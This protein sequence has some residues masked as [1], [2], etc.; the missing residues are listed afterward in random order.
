MSSCPI[1]RV[2]AVHVLS[3]VVMLGA[4]TSSATVVVSNET[5]PP[6]AA[7]QLKFFLSKPALVAKGELV[8][9]LDPTVFGSITTA[10]AFSANGD[11]YGFA[12]ISGLNVDVVFGSQSGG[13]GQLVGMPIVTVTA[14]VL[15]TATVGQTASVTP[16]PTLFGWAD[17]QGNA[18]A[19]TASAGTVTVGGTLSI[20]GVTPGGGILPSGTSIEIDGTGFS[21]AATVHI[22]GASIASAQVSNAGKILVTLGGATELTGKPVLVTN[23]DGSE[24]VAFSFLPRVPVSSTGT[25]F[26]GVVPIMPLQTY[27]VATAFVGGNGLGGMAIRNPNPMAAQLLVDTTNAVGDFIGEQALT[28][29]AGGSILN[30]VDVSTDSFLVI[31]SAPVQVVQ[32]TQSPY[33]PSLFSAAP[34]SAATVPALQVT[35]GLQN[36]ALSWV[37]QTGGAGP[38]AQTIPLQ[39]P[40]GLPSTNVAV[41]IATSS[42][43]NWLSVTPAGVIACTPSSCSSFQVSANPA[44][45]LPGIYRGTVT[46]TPVATSLHAAVV[47]MVIPVAITVTASSIAGTAITSVYLAPSSLS[48]AVTIPSGLFSGSFSLSIV[49]DSGGNWLSAV[50]NAGSSPSSIMVTANAAGF[51]VGSY[52]GDIVISGSGNTLVVA[53]HFQVEGSIR[54]VAIDPGTGGTLDSLNFSAQAGSGT[55]PG[56]LIAVGN[57]DCPPVVGCMNVSPDLSSLAA[58][59]ATH[60]GGNWLSASVSS[61]SVL[62]GANATGL[63]AG[64]YL[65]AVTLTANGVASGQFPVVLVVETGTTPALVSFPGLLSFNVMTGTNSIYGTGPTALCVSSGS[66]PLALSAQSSTSDGRSWLQ[67]N[68]AVGTTPACLKVSVDATAL[69]PG[70]YSGNIVITGGRQSVTVPVAVTVTTDGPVQPMLLGSVASAASELPAA[71]S[72]GEIIAIHGQ[73]LG[74]TTPAG[75]S[76]SANGQFSTTVAGVRVL[77]GGIPAPILY[78][79]QYEINTVVPYEVAGQSAL[80]VQVQNMSGFA[81]AWDIPSAGS[82]PGIFTADGTGVGG[83]AILNQ[84]NSLNTSSN[85][86][87]A[88]TVIQIFATGEGLT[89]PPGATGSLAQSLHQPVLPVSVTIGGLQAQVV[90]AGSAPSEIQGL[91]QVNAIVPA[92]IP[93]SD[94]VLVLLTVGLA[95]SQTATIAVR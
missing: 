19:V 36:G 7:V 65:G 49:T 61:G 8:M 33:V 37:W 35:A 86:A 62:V 71:V 84:D 67:V 18:Y 4:S 88:G 69:P 3:A 10:C 63:S 21:S 53:V 9:Q 95:P 16:T 22:D 87:A 83:G 24:V 34:L 30:I 2:V 28:I 17:P 81:P 79:S 85:P 11:A 27:T 6:G 57:E 43:G 20:A 46:L 31:A 26:D 78:A 64:V 68:G 29:P 50:P 42:G 77:I 90:Y 48:Q 13:V 56:Q 40:R 72:P 74:P 55:L 59:V 60:A 25:D 54:L 91:F 73:N 75:P 38:Q 45:L 52:T 15:S 12:R 39:L 51:G 47:P 76:V 66:V 80:S 58:S 92:G 5:V 82:A 32:I 93:T 23:P 1:I 14:V 89:N 44:G 41:S 94:A 70:S